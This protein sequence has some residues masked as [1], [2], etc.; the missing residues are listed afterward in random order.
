[1]DE[2]T[3]TIPIP[4]TLP[5]RDL[6]TKLGLPVTAITAELIKNGIMASINEMIDF[7]TATIIAEDLGKK[8]SLETETA[9][10]AIEPGNDITEWLKEEPGAPLVA[11]PPVVVIM[12]HVDH[13][14]TS[15][16]DTIRST[17]VTEGE[18]G[19]IT[20]HIGAYQITVPAEGE[21]LSREKRGI[22]RNTQDDRAHRT[23][24]FIDTPGHEAFGQMRARGAKIADVAILV[25]A[26]DD[27]VKPQTK[28]AL[29]ITLDAKI[30]FLVAI[31]K[32]DKPEANPDKVKKELSE[33]QVL[34]EEWGGQVPF[35]VVSAKAKT[36]LNELLEAVLLVADVDS[37]GLM[38]NPKRPA[39]GTIIE[40]HVDPQQG[41]IASVLIQTGTLK[42]GDNVAV[43]QVWGKIRSLKNDLGKSIRTAPPSTPVQI[44]GLKAAPQV[45]DVL[46]VSDIDAGELKKKVKSHQMRQHLRSVVGKTRSQTKSKEDQAEEDEKPKVRKLLIILKTDTVGSAEA[47]QESLK[48]IQ[49]PEVAV[50]IVQRGMGIISDAE[51][52]WAEGAKAS[53]YGFHVQVSPKAD[54]LAKSKGIL[55][56]NFDVIYDLI[57]DVVKELEVLLPPVIEEQEVGRLKVLA[58][59]RNENTFQVIGGKVTDG[60]ISLGVFVK[61]MRGGIEVA[62]GQ[63]TQL[64]SNKQNIK[65]VASGNE[66]GM[67]VE[68][69]PVIAVGD[70]LIASL[71]ITKVRTLGISR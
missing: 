4:A 62:S 66:C 36:G 41:P 39:I 23:I 1:M 3:P 42:V 64:Q 40:S 14:K 47:I 5:V 35:V 28:E 31:T 25:V 38:V 45:G 13:G 18:A 26:A 67:K 51:V 58:I 32:A 70:Q 7:E 22:L 56:K 50:E 53:I 43:G 46:R 52:L 59:F 9:T 19:G 49:H 12:G 68:C 71:K 60:A 10:P 2:I 63:I 30:P 48:K 11:R 33:L 65:E 61:I 15:L 34:S 27:G 24:T 69:Q 57:D 20:Q 8:V 21:P 54:Q 6:A 17:K 16:L 29:Q 55:I 44:L 37:S